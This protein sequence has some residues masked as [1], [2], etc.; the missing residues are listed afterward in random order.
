MKC[1][2]ALFREKNKQ[3]AGLNF[4]TFLYDLFDY[5]ELQHKGSFAVP[6]EQID[7]SFVLDH[8]TYLI[9]AKWQESRT[10]EKDLLVF[11]GKIEGKSSITRG[12]FIA[13]NGYTEKAVQALC[14]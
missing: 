13:L 14:T 5:F 7:G 2:Y 3:Q 11:R 8:D 4:E 6:R 12:V 9:K 10:Q 1:F